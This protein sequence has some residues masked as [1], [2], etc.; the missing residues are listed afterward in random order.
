MRIQQLFTGVVG[1]AGACLLGGLP[2]KASSRLHTWQFDTDQNRFIFTTEGGVQPQVSLDQDPNR[3]IIDLPGVVVDEAAADQ[4]IG[5][6]VRAV[7]VMQV[8]ARSTRM[9]LELDPHFPIDPS[10]VRV[11]AI[12]ESEWVVQLPS[13]APGFPAAEVAR[14]TPAATQGWGGATDQIAHA[15]LPGIPAAPQT[16]P[17]QPFPNQP[18]PNPSFTISEPLGSGAYPGMGS[19]TDAASGA[20]GNLKAQSTTPG[21]TTP[22][23]TTPGMT[24]PGATMPSLSPF[25]F[26]S[27]PPSPDADPVPPPS[28]HLSPR[29]AETPLPPLLSRNQVS[30]A[31]VATVATLIQGIQAT[32]QGFFI[33]LAGAV[34]QVQIYR[35][36]DASQM[37][38]IVIDILNAGIPAQMTPETLPSARYGISRWAVTQFATLPPAVRITLNLDSTSPDWQVSP[39]AGGL[40]LTPIGMAA[41]QIATAATTVVLPVIHA[42]TATATPQAIYPGASTQPPQAQVANNS[43]PQRGQ[44][45]V[46][47]DPGHGGAD[48]GAVGIGGLQEKGVVSA[49][50]HHVADALRSQGITVQM[51]RQGDETLD[52]QPRV[53][54]AAAANATVFVSIHANAVNMQRPEVNGLETYYFAETSLPLANAIHRRVMGS[55]SMNDRGV[56]QARFFVLRRTTMPAALVEIGFVTGALDAPKLRDPQWQAQM[57]QAIAQGILDYLQGRG[58]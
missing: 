15:S 23:M 27:A 21:M 3:L 29:I 50:S 10:Q 47:I 42:T 19:K 11:W 25:P 56:K 8:D 31:P 6:A 16:W 30:H 49:V 39:V 13:V 46:M 51:T 35:T 2:A 52:L 41:H 32:P 37:R 18:L 7:K 54:R 40:M 43:L 12:T 17:S 38:Q 33:P 14:L 36:R 20:T 28:L 34:P 45:V 58:R 53:D 1:V 5:G 24:T 26:P 22:G 9:V 57:G 44:V 48:P 4:F 55:V